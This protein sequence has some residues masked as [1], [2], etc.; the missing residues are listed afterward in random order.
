MV[1]EFVAKV[2]TDN[3]AGTSYTSIALFEAGVDG[4][5]YTDAQ[6]R[7]YTHG[8][9]TDDV[10]DGDQ[11]IGSENGYTSTVIHCTSTQIL[12]WHDSAAETYD[13]NEVLEEDGGDGEVTIDSGDG[14]GD[15]SHPVAECKASSGTADTSNCTF[16]N[17]TTTN[18][19]TNWII[20]RPA[21]G[22]EHP[23]YW[24]ATI[25]RLQDTT[26]QSIYANVHMVISGIQVEL[27]T[28]N[29]WNAIVRSNVS[30]VIVENCIIRHTNVAP[31]TNC[32]GV[33]QA[34]VRNC[35]IYGF[36]GTN[37]VGLYAC[38]NAHNCTVLDCTVGAN[39]SANNDSRNCV[40]ADNTATFDGTG[41]GISDGNVIDTTAGYDGDWV[42]SQ[43]HV[44]GTTDGDGS[45]TQK[46][47]DT[48]ADFLT[49]GVQINCLVSYGA[50]PDYT[51]VTGLDSED[52]LSVDTGIDTGVEY[53]VHT[54]MFGEPTFENKG[55]DDYRLD[56][57]DTVAIDKGI[58]LT[59][60][61]D[62]PV[63]EDCI[64]SSRTD[65]FDVGA[66]E[67][68]AVGG[69]TFPVTCT[70][71]GASYSDTVSI[72]MTLPRTHSETVSFSDLEIGVGDQTISHADAISLSDSTTSKETAAGGGGGG[73]IGVYRKKKRR[74]KLLY[75]RNII[76][77][78]WGPR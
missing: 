50:T 10:S 6:A 62:L 14:A 8:G 28:T 11:M 74:G 63:T 75:G 55:A 65:P 72:K 18:T 56:S 71:D 39:N 42:G 52:Q 54:D 69:E 60:H 41:A 40:Y 7:V 76:V 13:A 73:L 30:S 32:Y 26:S 15:T 22:Q 45:G 43:R 58:D 9:I 20:V 48:G 61:A 31:G 53:A 17:S 37:N 19:T 21:S 29:T 68:V 27:T 5:D 67:Y 34:N 47:M 49:N 51:F 2:D 35:M 46:L 77:A 25:Y 36:S 16:D 38:P 44:E 12:V 24:D 78:G 70:V 66:F 33:R 1:T 23:G 3:E 64:G 59:S 4:F 57:V